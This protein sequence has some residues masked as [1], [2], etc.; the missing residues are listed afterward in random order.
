[1]SKDTIAFATEVAGLSPSLMAELEEH[2]TA[3]FGEVLP[4]VFFGDVTRHVNELVKSISLGADPAVRAELET[5]LEAME[6]G[7][8]SG[9][10]DVQ[11]LIVV[12]FLENLPFAWE[13]GAEVRGMLGPNLT[14]EIGKMP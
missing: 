1:M 11:G 3:N 14:R 9:T 2:I 12:S 10:S 4:H 6:T 7:F 13:P 8:V 5:I